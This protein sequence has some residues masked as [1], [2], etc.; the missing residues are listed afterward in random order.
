MG[1]IG[2]VRVD[3]DRRGELG[4]MRL[5]GAL[6]AN[7][8]RYREKWEKVFPNSPHLSQSTPV[9]GN[10][11]QGTSLYAMRSSEDFLTVPKGAGMHTRILDFLLFS[12]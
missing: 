2:T 10:V 3:R 8:V 11:C 12:F 9:N 1:W 5:F 4:Q 6:G 7:H